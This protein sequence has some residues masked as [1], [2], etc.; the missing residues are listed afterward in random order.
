[1][2]LPYANHLNAVHETVKCRVPTQFITVLSSGAVLCGTKRMYGWRKSLYLLRNPP[3]PD[4][5]VC[6]LHPFPG[7]ETALASWQSFPS[8]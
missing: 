6:S 2:Q 5:H 8:A 3:P 1:M 7:S 4:P